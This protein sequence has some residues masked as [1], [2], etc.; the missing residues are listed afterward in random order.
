MTKGAE[1]P[2]IAERLTCHRPCR[3][4]WFNAEA[5]PDSKPLSGTPQLSVSC[6]AIAT[7]RRMAAKSSDGSCTR[8]DWRP[9][10]LER[11]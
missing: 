4:G 7:Q 1:A 9:P 11:V 8:T 5:E 2:L 10:R 3:A 6:K